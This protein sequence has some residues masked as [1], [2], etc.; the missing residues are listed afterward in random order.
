[1]D[2]DLDL[3]VNDDLYTLDLEPL[4]DCDFPI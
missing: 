3:D 1:L 4:L 2:L